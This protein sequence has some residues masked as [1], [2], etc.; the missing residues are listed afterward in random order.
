MVLPGWAPTLI[1]SVAAACTT[2][3]FVPQVLR[4]WRLRSAREVSLTT[5]TVFSGGTAAWLVYGLLIASPPVIVANAVTCLLSLTMVGMKLV[6]GR[7][8]G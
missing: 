7:T 2:G 4:V 3:A 5:F 1:G 6:Y 8:A